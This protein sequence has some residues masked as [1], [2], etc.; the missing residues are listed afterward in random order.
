MFYVSFREGHRL[1]GRSQEQARGLL[2]ISAIAVVAGV[3]AVMVLGAVGFTHAGVGAHDVDDIPEAVVELL[4]PDGAGAVGT[5][6]VQEEAQVAGIFHQFTHHELVV[7]GIHA[8][9]VF[10]RGAFGETAED[11]L[12]LLVAHTLGKRGEVGTA[13]PAL[14]LVHDEAEHLGAFG[15]RAGIH[16]A[17]HGVEVHF[18][19][20]VGALA[21]VLTAVAEFAVIA[22]QAAVR[23]AVIVA[24]VA[25][26]HAGRHPLHGV[27]I[28]RYAGR[29][30]QCHDGSEEKETKFLH[31]TSFIKGCEKKDW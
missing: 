27:E 6:A 1:T 13:F 4:H 18:G 15:A 9:I 10:G 8:V 25:C 2:S 5:G 17:E 24:V 21:G 29:E 23:G 28:R 26:R 22:G 7:V 12:I 3:V 20:A 31:G 11:M 14:L 30:R 19:R 16:V